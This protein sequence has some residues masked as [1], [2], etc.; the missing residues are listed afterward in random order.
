MK[1]MFLWSAVFLFGAVCSANAQM[2]P[3]Q[4]T[5]PVQA[6][7]KKTN[8]QTA[9]KSAQ[10]ISADAAEEQVGI[11]DANVKKNFSVENKEKVYDN[12]SRKIISFKIVNGEM[13][14]DKDAKRSILV[15]YDNYNVTQGIDGM[16]RCSIRIF[17]LND[18]EQKINNFGFQLKWPKLTASVQMNQLNPGVR[19]YKDI[20]LLGDGCFS[21]DK[22]PTIEINRCRVKGLSQEAC[23]DAV[24]WYQNKTK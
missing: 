9:N 8:T 3:S 2:L 17:V 22:T 21:M 1:K 19:T 14:I 20:A 18:L 4:K 24:K 13:I 12:S 23:A 5:E 16:T 6:V 10:K 15:Y 7:A 11:S